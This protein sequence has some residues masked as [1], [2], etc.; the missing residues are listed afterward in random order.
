MSHRVN[1]GQKPFRF[2]PPDGF[3]PLNAANVRPVKVISRPDQY[4]GVT[5]YKGNNTVGRIIDIGRNADLVWVKKRTAENNILV[6]TVRGE[7]NFLMSDS[8]NQA[9]T[10]GGPITGI[11]ATVYNGFIVDNNGY[12]NANNA[13]Y[14]CWNW[15]AGGA[16]TA[17]NTQSSGAM[18]ANSVS[19]DGVLQSAYTPSGSPTIYPK[20]MS[21]GTKQG[22]SIVQYEGNNTSGA[23]LPHGLTQAPDF[24]VTKATNYD[25]REW[26]VYHQGLGNQQP[27]R[28]NTTAAALSANAAYFNNTSPTANVVTFGNGGDANQGGETTLTYVMYAW[29]DVPGLQKFGSYS[30]N[31]SAT[32]G[33]FV[34]LG[35]KPAVVIIKNYV[36]YTENW[37]IFDNQRN[38]FNLVDNYLHPNTSGAEDNQYYDMDFL[39]NGF[40]L[41]NNA[42]AANSSGNS[43]KYIYAAWA[44]AP[45]IDLYGGGANAR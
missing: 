10:S 32:D 45:S 28:L 43:A 23:T 9:N 5:T 33:T 34:E 38:K 26:Q 11:G 27:I 24:F 42:A 7:N 37:L 18:T 22:F 16:P 3:Q 19:V 29:H 44:E 30:G 40:K 41:Y 17:T 21:V 13:D 14:V 2:P 15:K 20:K 12:V 25:N 35:F 6:D 4:V 8:G 31:G 36:G 39:S 1:F